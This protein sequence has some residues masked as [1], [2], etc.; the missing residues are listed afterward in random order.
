MST[1]T[2][3]LPL[4]E[5]GAKPFWQSLRE[6]AMKLQRCDN[7]GRF[8]YQPARYCP[9][10]LSPQHT[11]LPISGRGVVWAP[12]TYH[13]GFGPFADS[14][15]YNVSLIELEEGV[16]IWSNVV[17]CDPALV[18]IGMPVVLFYDDVADGWTLPRFRPAS[19]GEGHGV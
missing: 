5:P 17:N 4:I 8:R 9:D 18:R 11:W 10:C 1:Y 14:A 3:P 2:K 12:L 19:G 13:Q 6:H 16:R 7:C 15:P